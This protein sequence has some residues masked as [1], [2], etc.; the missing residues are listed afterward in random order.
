MGAAP[1]ICL[2][3]SLLLPAHVRRIQVLSLVYLHM[4]MICIVECVE[5][6]QE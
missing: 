2:L 5:E 4:K 6:S 3:S 1:G